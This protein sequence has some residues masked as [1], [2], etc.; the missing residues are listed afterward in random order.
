MRDEDLLTC[1]NLSKSY[2]DGKKITEVI[3]KISFSIRTGDTVA[4]LG[5]SGS[6]KSTLLHL[7]SGLEK[8]TSG[9]VFLMKKNLY[10]LTDRELSCIRNR[11]IGFVHQSHHLLSDFTVIE[12]VIMPLLIRGENYAKSIDKAKKLLSEVNLFEK[13]ENYS[14]E[15]SGGEKQRVSIV[16]SMIHDPVIILADEPTGN[17][18]SQNSQSVSDLFIEINRK[19]KT[20]FVVATHDNRLSDIMNRKITIRDGSIASIE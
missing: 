6:G 3:K 20:A 9:K 2:I 13:V 8:P 16:R 1:E 17:L 12:N 15:L 10:H 11:Y 19:R 14:S 4:I 18:D 7:L 5:N